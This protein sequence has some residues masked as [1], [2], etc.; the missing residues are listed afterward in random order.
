M[1]FS[2]LLKVLRTEK[3]LSQTQLAAVLGITQ[4]SISLWE[5]G[6][7]VPDTQYVVK[8]ADFFGVSTDYLLGRSDDF[9]NVN[10]LSNAPA[11]SEK[12]ETLL[13]YFRML[14]PELQG[15]ALDTVRVLAGIPASG[16]QKKA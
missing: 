10:I 7:R 4:D 16:L 12:E 14:S 9:G 15:A 13:Q 8:L 2:N 1:N 5:K 3:E 6:K 11:H